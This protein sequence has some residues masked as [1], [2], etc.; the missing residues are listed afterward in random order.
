[1]R[2]RIKICG[3]TSAKIARQAV[4]V[5]ADALGFMF[6]PKSSRY[7]TLEQAVAIQQHIPPFVARVGVLVNPQKQDVEEI[8]QE[9]RPDYLQFH[10]DESPAFCAC[11]GVPY[12]K[13]I[14]VSES[15]DL[16][17]LEKQYQEATGLLLDSHVPDCYGGSGKSF[18]WDKMQYDG[19]KPII[20]AGGLTSDNVQTAIAVAS[21]YAVDV[22]SGV[23]TDGIKDFEK[24]SKF[25]QNT[26]SAH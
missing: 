3:I 4:H 13:A 17:V 10:G 11:F 12:I 5:G 2:V 14:R 7:L 22:S 23:E 6:Y 18:A 21:P 19:E 24:M 15:T 9:L 25:C 8:L 16:R 1:M 20:L 26:L